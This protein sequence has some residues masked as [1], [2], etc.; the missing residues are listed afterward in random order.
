MS[1]AHHQLYDYLSNEFYFKNPEIF[2]QVKSRFFENGIGNSQD[3][4]IMCHHL[5]NEVF[6]LGSLS[7][8]LKPLVAK[9]LQDFLLTFI[10]EE[11]KEI[12]PQPFEYPPVDVA[13]L[14]TQPWTEVDN[15]DQDSL[16]SY[17]TLSFSTSS[18]SP[19][20]S[21]PY[22]HH[23]V[24]LPPTDRDQMNGIHQAF[25][26]PLMTRYHNIKGFQIRCK[27]CFDAG[28]AYED[29]FHFMKDMNGKTIC[30][31]LLSTMCKNCRQYGHTPKYCTRQ[32]F[33]EKCHAPGHL[34]NNCQTIIYSDKTQNT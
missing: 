23:Q 21:P 6:W 31:L 12:R 4:L 22:Q 9:L 25:V 1:L 7:P 29:C 33:C 24:L 2:L 16:S 13:S 5:Q 17:S 3:F 20:L 18:P 10:K 32:L 28:M 8:H 27:V 34:A 19:P 14:Q 11:K 15:H 26:K 30:P